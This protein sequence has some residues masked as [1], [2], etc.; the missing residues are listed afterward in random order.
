MIGLD[1]ICF[2]LVVQ[3]LGGLSNDVADLLDIF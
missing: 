3:I 1:A 2:G